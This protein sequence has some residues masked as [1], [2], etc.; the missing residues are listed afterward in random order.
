MTYISC[1]L[2]HDAMTSWSYSMT[3]YQA[4]DTEYV[5]FVDTVIYLQVLKIS[6]E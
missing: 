5:K 1:H 3:P 6:A 4:H 2:R